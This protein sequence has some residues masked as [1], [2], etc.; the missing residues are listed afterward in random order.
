MYIYIPW[1]YFYHS[2]LAFGRLSRILWWNILQLDLTY[3][4]KFKWA[5]SGFLVEFASFIYVIVD[6]NEI[7]SFVLMLSN[8]WIGQENSFK[9]KW[10]WA[11]FFKTISWNFGKSVRFVRSWPKTSTPLFIISQVF[12][13]DF[14]LAAFPNQT[15]W[16][17]HIFF[18]FLFE[19][20]AKWNIDLDGCSPRI[21]SNDKA[22]GIVTFIQDAC[23]V[24]L[25]VN[26]A[27]DGVG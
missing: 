17:P 26:F 19:Q 13:S 10:N 9:S 24:T 2:F 11:G 7:K 5:I 18:F 22:D 12:K 15:K 20:C 27:F 16:L 25:P 3:L 14:D 8:D 23:N 6:T 21:T 4:L 1:I